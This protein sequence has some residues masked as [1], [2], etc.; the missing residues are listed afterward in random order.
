MQITVAQCDWGEARL[1]DIEALLTDVACHIARLLR[2]PLAGTITVRLAPSDD[3]T[4]RTHYRPSTGDP[5]FIQLT[6]RGRKWDKFA[7]QF[8]HELCH[9]LSD[10]E[11][12]RDNPNNWFH[13]AICELASVFTLRRM[14]EKWPT[15]PPYPNW[16]GYAESLASY[17]DGELSREERQLPGSMA[18][19]TWLLLEEEALRRDTAAALASNT[20]ISDELRHKYAIVAY[21]LLPI[22]ESETAGWNA[23]RRLPNSSA[24]LKDY[25]RYWCSQV[26]SV[27]K[28][29]VNRII[30]ILED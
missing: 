30:Q 26:E 2:E 24:M 7:Y 18:L 14:A 27:D 23:V 1:P 3:W 8:S 16:A 4:P 10:Y 9:V 21:S 11:H 28:P 29:F 6:A 13:E 17:A 15:S 22:F 19:P 25:L 12:L 20:R 5:F